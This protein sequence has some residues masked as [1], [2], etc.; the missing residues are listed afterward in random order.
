M[1]EIRDISPNHVVKFG[2]DGGGDFLKVSLG[3]FVKEPM[4]SGPPT[5]RLLTTNILKTSGV[6]KHLL[7]AECQDLAEN[8]ENVKLLLEL[9]NAKKVHIYM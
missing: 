3:A 1:I 9:I 5:K 4:D 8:Y 6:K 2:I 7:V